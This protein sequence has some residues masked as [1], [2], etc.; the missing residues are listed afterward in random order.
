MSNRASDLQVEAA[1]TA[2]S[3]NYRPQ[4]LIA[5]QILPIVPHGNETGIF[6]EWDQKKAFSFP[7]TLRAD[8]TRPNTLDVKAS[9]RAFAVEEYALDIGITDREEKNADGVLRLR[10]NKTKRVQDAILMDQERRVA[11]LLRDGLNGETLSGGDLWSATGTA[12]IEEQIDDAKEAVRKATGG[13][14]PNVIIIPRQVT[15]YAKRHDYI[16]DLLKF[17]NNSLLV[18]GELP[19]Q[20]FGLKTVIPGALQDNG[21]TALQMEDVWGDD[22]VIAHVTDA[23]ELD[24]PSLGYIIRNG[25]FV[26]YTWREDAISTTWIRPTVMQTEILAHKGCG[27]VLRGVL[28]Q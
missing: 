7:D 28:G 4:N 19:E 6:W 11:K 20:V 12:N 26:T 24:S 9:K 16:R 13:L 14:E 23:P 3:I 10:Q 15:R 27:Y 1:L 8:G 2:F 17:T 21:P 22:I 25:D 18:N 5:D